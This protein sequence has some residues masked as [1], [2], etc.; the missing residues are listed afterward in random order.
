MTS[1]VV[2]S[3]RPVLM[4]TNKTVAK[5]VEKVIQLPTLCMCV[6]VRACMRVC[7]C[8]S[9]SLCVHV[10]VCARSSL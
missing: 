1:D 7:V 4:W 10:S 2:K 8:V 3:N 6:R 5:Q 9:V